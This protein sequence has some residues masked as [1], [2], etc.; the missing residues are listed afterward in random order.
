M[1]LRGYV[2]RTHARYCFVFIHTAPYISLYFFGPI[3][4]KG[5]ALLFTSC[6]SFG[7]IAGVIWG[8]HPIAPTISPKKSWEGFAGSYLGSA[9]VACIALSILGQKWYWGI[10]LAAVMVIASTAGDLVESVF[11]RRIGIKDMSNILPGHGGM[12][13]RLDSVL[14]AA[15]VGCL[16]FTFVLPL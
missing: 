10:P 13:D 7:Y 2:C 16:I 12:M 5:L 11:K 1:P 14:F 8:K 9:V 3:C 15:A 6:L 4:I